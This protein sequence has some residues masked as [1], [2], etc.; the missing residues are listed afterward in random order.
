MRKADFH[1]LCSESFVF[2]NGFPGNSFDGIGCAIHFII[3]FGQTD[4]QTFEIPFLKS[5]GK[6]SAGSIQRGAILCIITA[7]G[8][9]Q[10]RRV[11]HI[12]GERSDLVKR[13]CKRHESETGDSSVGGF[14]SD[15]AAIGCG[16]TDT[17]ACIG[18][19]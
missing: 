1:H 7:D 9:H 3:F 14:E 12:L 6:T 15:N 2:F 8:V 4:L 5:C 10:D 13:G 16:L 19:Q 17:S 18:T 11:L